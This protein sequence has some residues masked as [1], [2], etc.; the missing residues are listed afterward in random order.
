VTIVRPKNHGEQLAVLSA[1]LEHIKEAVKRNREENQGNA[2]AIMAVIEQLKA[3]LN[4]RKGAEKLASAIRVTFAGAI[5]A[6]I[7]KLVTYLS[8]M[9]K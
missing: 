4:E 2:T 9:P 1:E 8:A 3:D 5:G 6:S 7:V